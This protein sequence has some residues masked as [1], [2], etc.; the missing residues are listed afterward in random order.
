MILIQS[1]T[2]YQMNATKTKS[3]CMSLKKI[4]T[5]ENVEVVL[6]EM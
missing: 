4:K 5:V 6:L 1:M 2:A 3:T